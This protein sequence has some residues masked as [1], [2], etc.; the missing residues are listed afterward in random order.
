MYDYTDKRP[1]RVQR[2]E[3]DDIT[4]AIYK[5]KKMVLGIISGRMDILKPAQR[6]H[7]EE[8]QE[9]VLGYESGMIRNFRD[10]FK[11]NKSG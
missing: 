2:P 10:F 7:F 4:R 11:G 8:A 1:E 5:S 9:F 3:V 6:K